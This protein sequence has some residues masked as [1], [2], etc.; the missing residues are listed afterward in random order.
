MENRIHRPIRVCFVSLYAYHYFNPSNQSKFGGAELQL[1]LLATQLAKDPE[2]EVSFVVGDFGQ[3]DVD[4]RQNVKL[5]KF[6]NP[7]RSLKYFRALLGF[8]RLWK[9]LNSI[10]PDLCIQRAAGFETAE[11]SIY[12]KFTGKHFF[13]M[14][15]NE[16]DVGTKKPFWMPGWMG[17]FRWQMFKWGL[18]SADIVF[19]QHKGQAQEFKKHY[20]NHVEIRPSAHIIPN[21]IEEKNKE[22]ILWVSRC[23][24][25]KQP[26]IFIA[27]AKQFPKTNFVMIMP[28]SRDQ[29][30]FT[31]MID[32][33]KSASNLRVVEYVHF[34][35]ID[36]FFKHALVFVNT[37]STEG[38]PNTFIQALKFKTP[39]LSFRIDLTES[40][41]GS[42]CANGDF[43]KLMQILNRLINDKEYR[44]KLGEQGFA[45]VSQNHDLMKIV[46]QDKNYIKDVVKKNR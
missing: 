41:P 24:D 9:L 28:I 7:R 38:F 15:A 13:Y 23:E 45:F 30:Y 12:C 43:Q 10:N 11:V 20:R 29:K 27:L 2:F 19:V 40:L 34:N 22:N 32:L 1:F 17:H 25:Y 21:F 46:E 3:P 26:E 16:L 6:F 36:D 37:S 14:V 42:V 33:S 4:I 8:I 31:D 39:V 5:Y 18:R 44:A 35:K